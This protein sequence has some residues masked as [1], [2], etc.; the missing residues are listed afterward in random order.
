MDGT[1]LVILV[2]ACTATLLASCTVPFQPDVALRDD[3]EFTMILPDG[4]AVRRNKH[5]SPW[6]MIAPMTDNDND[7]FSEF[8]TVGV[9]DSTGLSLEKLSEREFNEELFERVMPGFELIS[10]DDARIGLFAAKRIVYRHKTDRG[11][12]QAL[13]YQVVAGNRGYLITCDAE[14]D[15]YNDYLPI[16]ERVC[17]SFRVEPDLR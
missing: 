15:R 11:P 2:F 4:W 13:T 1:R 8:I 12:F 6:E 7:N 5:D 10:K 17:H 16:F 9:V 14:L 3:A